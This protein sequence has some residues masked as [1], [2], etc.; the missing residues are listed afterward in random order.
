[1]RR[2]TP[3]PESLFD[4]VSGL[5]LVILLKKQTPTQVLSFELCKIFRNN[6]FIEYLWVVTSREVSHLRLQNILMVR[7][8]EAHE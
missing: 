6:V 5:Q 4:K 8:L 2:K 3:V 7:R 1:M